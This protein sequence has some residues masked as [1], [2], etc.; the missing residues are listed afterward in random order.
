VWGEVHESFTHATTPTTGRKRARIGSLSVD[1]TDSNLG[2]IMKRFDDLT[3]QLKEQGKEFS[4]NLDSKT[5]L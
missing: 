5:I 4:K 3:T 1:A 2:I